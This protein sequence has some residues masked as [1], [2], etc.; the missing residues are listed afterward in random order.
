M[1]I[2]LHLEL[3]PD[4]VMAIG[5]PPTSASLVLL[6]FQ[7]LEEAKARGSRRIWRRCVQGETLNH[8]LLAALIVFCEGHSE[9]KSDYG[10]WVI[11]GGGV[12]QE[13]IY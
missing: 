9:L 2:S 8:L 11:N 4:P 10:T 1:Y 13:N 7:E 12:D 6:S 3:T 5:L